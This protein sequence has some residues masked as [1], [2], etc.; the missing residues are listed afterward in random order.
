[1][2]NR[3]G[4]AGKSTYEMAEKRRKRAMLY[5]VVGLGIVVVIWLLISNSKAWGIGGGVILLLF[6]AANM[7]PNLVDRG[8]RQKKK[9]EKRAIRG[10]KA[11][12]KVDELL[13][14]LGEG[15]IIL[16]DIDSAYGNIDHL[17]ISRDGGIIL[18]ETKAHGGRVEQGTDGSLLVNGH[19]PEKDFISQALRNSFWVRDQVEG[20]VGEKPWITPVL[21]F[22][23]AFVRG[24]LK[25]K[26]VTVVNKKFLLSLIQGKKA[27][28]AV[29]AKVW[30]KREA[31]CTRLVGN[32][33]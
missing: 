28:N 21:V 10:A 32:A 25:I 16:N 20:L 24:S 22:T 19:A 12:E 29:T 33:G 13:G 26:G 7:I 6:I 18:L 2:A 8:V 11:D 9:E 3:I 1:M 27:G 14:E 23:N 30:E 31:I 4:K 17:V 15:F 5:A